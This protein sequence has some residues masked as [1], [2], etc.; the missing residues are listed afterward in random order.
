MGAGL[1]RATRQAG[2]ATVEWVGMCLVVA[3]LLAGLLAAIGSGMPA[4][5]FA[6][7]IALRLLCAAGLSST[8]ADSGDLAAA[9]GPELAAEVERN[10]PGNGVRQWAGLGSRVAL[11]HRRAG[12]GVRPRRRLSHGAGAHR[13]HR[14]RL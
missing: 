9:Y 3:A 2:Q 8:C 7:S 14:K 4:G 1:K 12:R 13:E 11:R 5:L 10:A 6:K